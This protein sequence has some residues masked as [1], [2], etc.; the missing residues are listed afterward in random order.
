[1]TMSECEISQNPIFF[2]MHHK[3]GN[4]YITNVMNEFR[5]QV[6]SPGFEF[7]IVRAQEFTSNPDISTFTS[8]T[9]T[10]LRNFTLE[11]VYQLPSNSIVITFK[12][13]PRSL[14]VSCVD[15]HM[16]GSEHWTRMPMQKYGGQPYCHYLRKAASDED[17]LIISMENRAGTI[18]RNMSTFLEAPA[19]LSVKL[20]DVA[21]DESCRI[22]S[23]I[24]EYMQLSDHN[25]NI[26]S[27]ILKKHS[28][29]H[30]KMKTGL[31]PDH[32]TSGVSQDSINRLRGK[33]LERY[34]ELFGDI[35]RRLGYT[36]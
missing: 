3:C 2:A 33:A 26:L 29:W 15:Y 11:M 27:G 24:C 4:S 12:R 34:Q 8:N 35:H 10:R 7:N 13:D 17:R 30:M 9:I 16:R 14:I 32:S 5:N 18:I 1:M 28:L 21:R 20:E 6:S 22:Y 19:I 25:Q 23:D 31:L 36:E